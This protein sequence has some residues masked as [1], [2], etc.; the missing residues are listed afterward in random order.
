MLKKVIIGITPNGKYVVVNGKGCD[1]AVEYCCTL[2]LDGID[3]IRFKDTTV[4]ISVKSDISDDMVRLLLDSYGSDLEII[5][6][7]EVVEYFPCEDG[8]IVCVQCINGESV[9]VQDLVFEADLDSEGYLYDE[10]EED[11]E[12]VLC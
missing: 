8:V 7:A 2:A 6:E 11:L 3:L 9:F 12:D 10:D 5:S 1:F 4:L